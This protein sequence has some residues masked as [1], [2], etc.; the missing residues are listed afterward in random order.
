MVF[1]ESPL[2]VSKRVGGVEEGEK[3]YYKEPFR[4]FGQNRCEVDTAVV[5][6]VVGGA[7]FVEW[8]YPVKF[9]ER[10]PFWCGEKF[11]CEERDGECKCGGAVFKDVAGEK[12]GSGGFRDV[13]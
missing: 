7:F 5:V 2:R 13:E 3:W 1:F 9:P 11:S 10:W 6:G 4:H 12:V 8:C